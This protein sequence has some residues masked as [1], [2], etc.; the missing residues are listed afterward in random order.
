MLFKSREV[1]PG[2][3]P[4]HVL[5]E[6]GMVEIVPGSWDL[7]A[8]GDPALSR[9]IKLDGPS[10][11]VVELKGRKRFS[12]GIWAPADQIAALRQELC[13]ERQDPSHQKRLDSGRRRRAAAQELYAED[14]RSAVLGFLGFHPTYHTQAERLAGLVVLHAA[15]VGSG[16][17][18]RTQRIPIEERAAAATIAWL[19]H[20][21][22]AYDDMAIPRERGRRR[23]V[24]RMLARR[25][26]QLL[27]EYRSGRPID[28]SRCP[29]NAALGLGAP[30]EL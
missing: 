27:A 7:L 8:P 11:T 19:R 17:V 14:F 18:A 5:N 2:P 9:R 4:R 10:L 26:S 21:T 23:E 25:S 1:R 20:Q 16:T 28:L 3:K 22:T 13:R 12:R 15:P 6:H 30:S 29:L 24:R